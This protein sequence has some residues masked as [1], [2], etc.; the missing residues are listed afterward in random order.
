M[1]NGA[2]VT[3]AVLEDGDVIQLGQVLMRYLDV[4]AA[5]TA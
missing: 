1:V 2:R 3:E 5:R 4:P